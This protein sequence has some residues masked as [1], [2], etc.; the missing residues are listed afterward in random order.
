MQDQRIDLISTDR[1][2]D[3]LAR[4]GAMVRLTVKV[5]PAG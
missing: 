5:P 4:L 1:L 2:I 3:M